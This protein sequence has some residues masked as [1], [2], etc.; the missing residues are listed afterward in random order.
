[1]ASAPGEPSSTHRR[2]W[3][4]VLAAGVLAGLVAWIAGELTH[5]FFRPRRYTVQI[6][7]MSS[8]QPS[9]ESQKAA[10]L[11]NAA[12]G[13]A[14]LGSVT[15]LA[16]GL[17]G[18]LAGRT[19]GRGV[20]IGLGAMAV[21]ACAGA[22]MTLALV[23]ILAG[24]LVPDWNDLLTPI[25]IHGGIWMAIGAVGG[26][27]FAISL[28]SWHQLPFIIASACL[29]A[30]TASILYHLLSGFFFPHSSSTEAVGG[31]AG[32]RLLAT[33]LVTILVAI[34]VAQG[35]LRRVPR[36]ARTGLTS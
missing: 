28:R 15:V 12:L 2:V 21:G 29:G 36:P 18:G 5:Q 13:S 11:A 26:L 27:A 23:P 14:I 16:M 34:G 19:A 32:I 8:E 9:R 22:G 17:A 4:I 24:Q 25:L 35:N 3:T 10:D 20:V 6:M 30:F 1:M 7:G 31:S 33:S